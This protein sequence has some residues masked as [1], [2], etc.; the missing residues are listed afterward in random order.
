MPDHAIADA[1]VV[2][3]ELVNNAF[4]HGAGE[5]VLNAQLHDDALRLEVVDQGTGHAPAIREQVEDD[6]GGWGLQLVQA[7]S[8]RWGAFEGTTHVWADI[9]VG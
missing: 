7:L 6:T 5:I 1:K 8:T 9:P 3:S 4:L 2:V